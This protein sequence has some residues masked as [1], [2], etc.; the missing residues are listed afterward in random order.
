MLAPDQQTKALQLSVNLISDAGR[1]AAQLSSTQNQELVRTVSNE[2]GYLMALMDDIKIST[3]DTTAIL[4]AV[5]SLSPGNRPEVILADIRQVYPMIH[6]IFPD[7]T[8]P[9]H[10]SA[11]PS[12]VPDSS[13]PAD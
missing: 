9:P 6:K 3:P 2:A 10:E 4:S 12:T 13:T 7:V 11:A 8:Q 1:R 5:R